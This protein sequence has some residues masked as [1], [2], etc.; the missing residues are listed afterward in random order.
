MLTAQGRAKRFA[1]VFLQA[2]CNPTLGSGFSTPYSSS[3]GIIP[4]TCCD[5]T[6][7]LF[8]G[9]FVFRSDSSNVIT[10]SSVEFPCYRSSGWSWRGVFSNLYLVDFHSVTSFI[11]WSRGLHPRRVDTRHFYV[12]RSFTDHWYLLLFFCGF[13]DQF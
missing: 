10:S 8:L 12:C 7:C 13:P 3:R 6:L 2:S 5:V 11:R 4:C 1:Y 9:W